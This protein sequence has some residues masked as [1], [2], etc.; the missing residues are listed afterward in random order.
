MPRR[1]YKIR[2]AAVDPVYQS[3]L[4]AKLINLVMKDGK[5]EVAQKLVYQTL[6][7]FK[8]KKLEPLEVF[9][10]VVNNIGPRMV[11]RPRRIGGA[12]Y[13]V[14]KEVQPKHRL[15]LALKWLVDASRTRPNKEYHTFTDKLYAEM[16]DAYE[17]KGAAVDK[18]NQAQ[19]LAEANKVFAHFSW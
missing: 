9:E 16:A 4:V 13:M 11:V 2:K 15:F 8:E 5:R 18:N 3:P 6:D 7:K 14:P 1:G 19:K 10:K 12:S 17:G